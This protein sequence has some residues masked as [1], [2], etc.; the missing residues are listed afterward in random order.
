[1]RGGGAK[2]LIFLFFMVP[3]AVSYINVAGRLSIFYR[4]TESAFV[5]TRRGVG[6]FFIIPPWRNILHFTFYTYLCHPDRGSERNERPS[7]GILYRTQKQG[8]TRQKEFVSRYAPRKISPLGGLAALLGRND[9]KRDPF[10]FA[11]RLCLRRSAQGD[12]GGR[13]RCFPPVVLSSSRQG[14]MAGGALH[15]P[16]CPQRL[17]LLFPKSSSILFG[18]PILSPCESKDLFLNVK[19]RMYYGKFR[20]ENKILFDLSK[21]LHFTLYILHLSPS[22]RPSKASRSVFFFSFSFHSPFSFLFLLSAFPFSPL[23]ALFMCV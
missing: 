4:A 2:L 23:A 12:I 8:R 22:S 14:A 9:R 19:F 18:S 5:W 6:L 21:I 20:K 1:M 11:A 10:D 7:R 13:S 16:P 3:R 15:L 17:P